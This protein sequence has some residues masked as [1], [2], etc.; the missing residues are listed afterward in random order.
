MHASVLAGSL[1][2]SQ[3][4]TISNFTLSLWELHCILRRLVV[5]LRSSRGLNIGKVNLSF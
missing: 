1:V 4:L 5:F 3:S 2:I